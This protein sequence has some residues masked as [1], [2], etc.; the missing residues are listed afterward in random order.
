MSVDGSSG[1]RGSGAGSAGLRA[2]GCLALM[3]LIGSTTAPAAKITVREVPVGLIP[4]VRFGIAGLCLWPIVGRGGVLGRM[5]RQDGWRLVAAASLCVPINQA[6]F[7]NGARLAPASHIGLIYAA[8]P[9]VVLAL[10]AALGQERLAS[11][12]IL[13]VASSMAGVALIAFENVIRADPA[14]R[15]VLRGDLLEVGAVLAWGA[16]LTV[17]KPLVNRHG[18]LP[19]LAATFLVGCVLDLP[20]ALTTYPTWPPLSEV[21]TAAWVALAYLAVVVSIGG[22]AF[23]NLSMRAL[24]AS[25]VATFGNVAPLLTVLWGYLLFDER[26]SP[27]AGVGGALVLLGIAWSSRPVRKPAVIEMVPMVPKLVRA[28]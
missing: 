4:L 3:V 20:L 6:F 7:L 26:I 11:G 5:L 25:Q 21:S 10:A 17:N 22:L 28:G 9:L 23:Q 8:C 19:T 15:D 1:V 12:R 27:I 13:G 14:G 24:D 16:Y 18:A 2:F